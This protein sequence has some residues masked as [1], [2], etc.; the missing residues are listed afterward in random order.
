MQNCP[1]VHFER[2]AVILVF[3]GFASFLA[4]TQGWAEEAVDM[5]WFRLKRGFRSGHNFSL[6]LQSEQGN[7]EFRR[8]ASG[9]SFNSR[10]ARSGLIVEYS[11]QIQTFKKIGF[12]LGS[13]F[14]QFV[15]TTQ[16]D[17]DRIDIP[18]MS[19]LP[20]VKGGGVWN[21]DAWNRLR[22]SAEY[23]LES[24]DG[25]SFLSDGK[26]FESAF[27]MT[28]INL[29]VQYEYFYSSQWAMGMGFSTKTS[30]FR[31]PSSI[32]SGIDSQLDS[33]FSYRSKSIFLGSSL[34]LL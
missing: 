31:R 11:Y 16:S 6:L 23:G 7:W 26:R 8:P 29:Q 13:S 24:Y 27:T 25:A 32:S 17:L 1:K 20:G 28:F 18:R 3:L 33:E 4:A 22:A 30:R 15:T 21:L 10:D 9:G 34:S 12:E 5:D 14:G 19:R 2:N